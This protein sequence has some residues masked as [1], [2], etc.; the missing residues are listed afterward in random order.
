MKTKTWK[1]EVQAII[2]KLTTKKF[3]L[4]DLYKHTARLSKRHADNK[5]VQAKI[6][7]TL[8]VLRDEGKVQFF[9]EGVYKVK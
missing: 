7:Q 4:A 1:E 8:Q 9:G 2:D 6:R 5:H 3:E